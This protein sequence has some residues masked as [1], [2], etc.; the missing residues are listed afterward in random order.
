MA[1]LRQIESTQ[2]EEQAEVEKTWWKKVWGAFFKTRVNKVKAG[3]A[4]MHMPDIC[5]SKG[6]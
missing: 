4:A 6:M 2:G 1:D 3:L 5:F